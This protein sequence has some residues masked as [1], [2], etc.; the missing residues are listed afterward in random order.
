MLTRLF[1]TAAGG[2]S[3]LV[4]ISAACI[5][6]I[7]VMLGLGIGLIVGVYVYKRNVQRKRGE[8]VVCII[9][10]GAASESHKNC[11]SWKATL[12]HVFT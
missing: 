2:P 1:P 9:Y 4:K 12:I 8:L 6:T 3:D 11:S 10:N 5:A 7:A